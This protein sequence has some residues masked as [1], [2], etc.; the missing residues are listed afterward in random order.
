MK[1][2][3]ARNLLRER[4]LRVI[5][6]FRQEADQALVRAPWDELRG[7]KWRLND[8]LSGESYDRDGDEMRDAG[9]YVDLG[10]WQCHLF[11]FRAG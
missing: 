3:F 4:V 10:P 6:N 2:T 11:Q 9:L 5:I 8:L 1:S 7:K